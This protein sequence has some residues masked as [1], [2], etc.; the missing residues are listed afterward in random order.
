MR[1]KGAGGS[2]VSLKNPAAHAF[3]H[4]A[5][6]VQTPLPISLR[7]SL[8]T[9]TLLVEYSNLGGRTP[10]FPK[11][12][13]LSSE[14]AVFNGKYTFTRGLRGVRRQWGGPWG[15][16]WGHMGEGGTLVSAAPLICAKL[17]FVDRHGVW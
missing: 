5:R 2:G 15:E 8:V 17:Y 7:R 3:R 13:P 11:T 12:A 1:N 14:I 9:S 16:G 4:A 6:A 10:R